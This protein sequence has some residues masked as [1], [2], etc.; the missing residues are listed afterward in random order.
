[1]ITAGAY[2][3]RGI[4]EVVTQ[5]DISQH[6]GSCRCRRGALRG[7]AGRASVERR[8]NHDHRGRRVRAEWSV[9]LGRL[10][11]PHGR[12]E[13]YVHNF[14]QD[15]HN[16]VVR[17]LGVQY[18]STGRIASGGQKTL[19]VTLKPGIYNVFCSLPGHRQLGMAAKLT[20]T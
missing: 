3:H 2:G 6:E 10:K 8:H 20:V 7:R 19:A 4:P 11:A 16:I 18:G 9:A 1:V 12:I 15:D 5:A 17:R 13:L 14:G